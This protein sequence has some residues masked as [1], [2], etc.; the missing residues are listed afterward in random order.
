MDEEEE[1][2]GGKEKEEEE[3]EAGGSSASTPVLALPPCGEA[4]L[5]LLHKS[6][7]IL[8]TQ[9]IP[10]APPQF[11]HLL[12]DEHPHHLL[13]PLLDNT[14]ISNPEQ[15]LEQNQS[16]TYETRLPEVVT[17]HKYTN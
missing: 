10:A 4:N 3:R 1:D 12:A 11:P 7:K 15:N 14:T 16:D 2:E 5:T 9:K 17:S 6:S 13:P 8:E